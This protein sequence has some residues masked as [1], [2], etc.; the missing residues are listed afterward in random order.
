MTNT[1][2]LQLIIALKPTV[3]VT[4]EVTTTSGMQNWL[5]LGVASFALLSS[6]ASI[7]FNYLTK[8]NGYK[9]DYY[10]K[11]IDKRVEALESAEGIVNLFS[12]YQGGVNAADDVHAYFVY[13]LDG[14]KAVDAIRKSSQYAIWYSGATGDALSKFSALIINLLSEVERLKD[15][16]DATGIRRLAITNRENINALA[17]TLGENIGK[18]MME[19]Y[20][21]K[22]FFSA[23]LQG[24]PR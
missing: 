22:E 17:N 9:N 11:V 15:K 10:K 23:K 4:R 18:D 24:L 5:P 12:V 16:G 3:K 19:L 1:V 20:K 8:D 7:I 6:L 2:L 14:T 21:V 13:E